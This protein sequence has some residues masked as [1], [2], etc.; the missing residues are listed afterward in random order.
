L[1]ALCGEADDNEGAADGKRLY[2]TY[3]QLRR[4]TGTLR[5]RLRDFHR[6][7]SECVFSKKV[8]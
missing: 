1:G 3:A 5:S 4:L 8:P 2:V 6:F 7:F